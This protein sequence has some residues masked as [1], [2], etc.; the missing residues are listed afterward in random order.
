MVHLEHR[1]HSRTY[2]HCSCHLTSL[3]RSLIDLHIV[4]S[5]TRSCNRSK[6][7]RSL[8]RLALVAMSGQ[9]PSCSR[10]RLALVEE[11]RVV[12]SLLGTNRHH[13]EL[14]VESDRSLILRSMAC[15]LLLIRIHC[16]ALAPVAESRHSCNLRCSC[17]NYRRRSLNRLR[18]H[19]DHMGMCRSS[20]YIVRH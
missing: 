18:F 9:L 14:V 19:T 12:S 4:Y 3:V 1:L 13:L 20:V 5:R 17:R 15:S 10:L 8:S 11:L 16:L 7:L 6:S 2:H